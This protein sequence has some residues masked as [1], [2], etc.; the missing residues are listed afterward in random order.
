MNNAQILAKSFIDLGVKRIFGFSG[1]TILPVFHA[2]D[3]YGIDIIVGAN[4]QSCAFAAGGYS[5]SSQEVGVA[6]V[7]SG[8]AI[9]NTLT[10]VADANADS[11]PLLVF[12][13]QVARTKMGTDEFQHINVASIFADAAKKVILVSELHSVEE[14]VKDAY[15]LA[16]SG[17]P[18][19]V[20]IDFP[21]DIQM[22][23]GEYRGIDPDRF[24]Y[25]YDEE[26]HLG[27]NQCQQFFEL[28]Q[29]AKRPLLYIGGGLNSAEGSARI[30]EFNRRYRVPSIWSLM[31][32]GVLNEKGDWA[33]GML[34]MFGVPAANMAIQ[35][36]DLFV[37]FGI[38][39]DDRVSQKV[40]EAGLAAD[41]AYFDINPQKVQEV[42][43]S[44]NPKFS[45]I[46]KAE[47]A[48]DDLLNYAEQ[49]DI[50]LDIGDWQT[51]TKSLK[52]TYRL[53][54]NRSAAAIQQAEVMETL[55]DFITEQTIITTGVGNHQ[56]LAAQYLTTLTPKSFLTSGGYGTMG[57]GLPSAIGA[58]HA[59]PQKIVIAID[60]DGSLLMN[61]GELFT[62]GKYQLPVKVLMLN[63]H[64]DC[65]VRNIQDIVY[66]G[67]H[68]GTKKVTSVSFANVAKEM[69]F[70]Y[71]R[72]VGERADLK[73]AL[74]EFVQATGPCFLEVVTDVDEMLYPRIPAGL[75][76]KDMILGPYMQQA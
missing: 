21:Y 31:G 32:K 75:G 41:I 37:A 60:G 39:W 58:Q 64:G 19:P 74:T 52:E 45:F 76:Y 4:E 11:I 8:P 67:A 25:K 26:H 17:K 42:R 57:F 27:E 6:V 66:R 28:L 40:G 34:G 71:S 22:T 68:V 24:R 5:R 55:S 13:G 23:E 12:A 56:M 14:V 63:N 1:A 15:F 2:I 49:N 38:R 51:Y 18:G 53:N 16:K 54:Y 59:N 69:G 47:T 3:E 30:R 70:S 9:T 65:M 73:E 61:L 43:F 7:T 62:V 10:A 33:L 50:R 72:R 48:L 29:Q 20:V 36:T 35:K 46:G 44:R